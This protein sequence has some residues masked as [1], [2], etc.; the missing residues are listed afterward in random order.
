MRRQPILLAGC[1][2]EPMAAYLKALGVFRLLA[3]QADP[4]A[5][6]CWSPS[7]LVLDAALSLDELE[8]FFLDRYRPT[9]IVSPWNSAS[10]FGAEGAC[11]LGTIE[12]STDDRLEPYRRAIAVCRRL[13][14]RQKSE[15]WSKEEMVRACRAELPEECVAWIDASV[16]LTARRPVY[17]PLLGTGGNDL[18]LEFSRNF[19]QRVL[20]VLGLVRARSAD[21]EGWLDDSLRGTEQRA[22]LRGKSPGQFDGGAAG[23]PNSAPRGSADALLNPWD[24][25]FLIEGTLLFASG[26]ARRLGAET[27]GRVAAP[28]TVDGSAAGYASA[29]PGEDSR[30]EIWL[31]IWERSSRLEEVRALLAEG[32]ADWRRRHVRTGL[33][34]AEAAASLG[35]DRAITGFSRHALLVRNGRSVVATPVGRVSVR[36][37]PAARLLAQLDRWLDGVRTLATSHT[38]PAGIFESLRR[39][40]QEMFAVAGGDVGTR[41][42]V[43]LLET[44]IAVADLELAVGRSSLRERVRALTPIGEDRPAAGRASTLNASTWV[45]ELL[46]A[47]AGAT[48]ELRLAMALASC[49]DMA[50]TNDDDQAASEDSGIVDASETGGLHMGS[51]LRDLLCLRWSGSMVA[52]PPVLGLEHRPVLDVLADAHARRAVE[53]LSR[54]RRREREEPLHEAPGLPTRFAR[55][56]VAPLADV[57]AL[58]AGIV[59]ERLLRDSLRA[60]LLLDFRRSNLASLSSALYESAAGAGAVGGEISTV[61]ALAVLGPFYADQTPPAPVDRVDVDRVDGQA[62]GSSSWHR[63][64]GASNLVPEAEW[65]ALLDAGRADP[66]LRGAVR[67]LRIAGL[68]PVANEARVARG[69]R[70]DDAR[71]LGAALLCPIGRRARLS[72]LARACPAP[73]DPESREKE[74]SNVRT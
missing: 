73:P 15:G 2:L 58:A 10:G 65:P 37:R 61:P 42:G 1:Q 28:F 52:N 38:F 45:P 30:G 67:R 16:V 36:D 14:E 48:R 72:L 39:V 62:E 9:P 69:L 53:L 66:V 3:E 31:P 5:T 63:R 71:R 11:E 18:R 7:G 17:P 40:D 35:V 26:V 4:G 25:V 6:A 13:L 46:A 41:D 50:S 29:A 60:C 20:D 19:H 22:A 43:R 24:W 57:A 44:L 34:F 32:R 21:I 70:T 54:S 51:S 33:E 64:L 23:G 27:A 55:S 49:H 8:S 68:R 12:S 47:A 56:I 59:D 74:S